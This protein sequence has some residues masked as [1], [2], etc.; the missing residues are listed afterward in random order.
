MKKY[1][2]FGG[3]IRVNEPLGAGTKE[4]TSEYLKI[5]GGDD[6]LI[7]RTLETMKGKEV[8]ITLKNGGVLTG[9]FDRKTTDFL[10]LK[11]KRWVLIAEVNKIEVVEEAK[12]RARILPY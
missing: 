3:A 6:D 5:R 8:R 12:D 7:A 4:I 1:G 2:S 9:V 10:F 11:D